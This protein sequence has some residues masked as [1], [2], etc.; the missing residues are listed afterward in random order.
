MIWRGS[1]VAAEFNPNVQGFEA[2]FQRME[3]LREEIGK[4]KTDRI[5]RNCMKYAMEPVLQ[6]AISNAP[7][8]EK[9]K[10]G[11]IRDHIYLK[12]HKPMSRDKSS[13]SYQGEMY[14]ARVTASPIRD[15]SK[16]AVVLNKR[17]KFQTVRTGMPPVGVSQEFGNARTPAHP[18]MRPA[19]LNN[20]DEVQSRLGEALMAQIAKI[21]ENKG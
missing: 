15:S 16:L 21:A 4:G 7:Y 2:L 13:S 9:S 3:A 20:T 10:D 1:K 11:H 6:D 19:I 14:M 17:G 18:F 12:V 5:W 8:D